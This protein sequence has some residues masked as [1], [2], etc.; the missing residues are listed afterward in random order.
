M[1]IYSFLVAF[2]CCVAAVPVVIKLALRWKVFDPTGPLKL[3]V[4]PISRLGGVALNLAFAVGII[5]SDSSAAALYLLLAL[6]L[7]GVTGVLDDVRSLSPASRFVAQTIAGLVLCYGT[8]LTIPM[9]GSKALA[10]F[11]GSLFVVTLVNA[12][13]LLDG[14]DGVATGVAA[15]IASGYLAL[16]GIQPG[17]SRSSEWAL[18]GGCLG[19]LLF[20]FPPAKIFLG[21]SG[22]TS[23][24]LVIAFT[25]L[26]LYKTNPSSTN[27]LLIPLTFAN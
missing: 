12:F 10:W 6:A 21:D 22:S 5:V 1:T 19:F 18:L 23:L 7:L 14:A 2:V 9:L 4:R 25:G 13:N 24:G 20:N 27:G 16:G 11:M 8:D 15:I 26:E 17:V 3:H